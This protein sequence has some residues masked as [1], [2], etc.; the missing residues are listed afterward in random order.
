MT[1]GEIISIPASEGGEFA[2]YLAGPAGPGPALVVIQEIFGINAA[3]R[4]I[5]DRLASAGYLAA[6]PDLFWR[7]EPGVNLTDQTEEDWKRAIE[8]MTGFDTDKGID[9]IQ[10]T[11]TALRDRGATHVGTVGFCLGGKLA[12]LSACRTDSEASVSYYGV[13]IDGLLGEATNIKHPLLMHIAAED[14]FVDKAAQAAIH[15]GLE[16]YSLVTIHDY[17]GV[18]HAFARPNGINFDAEAA[19]LADSRT[20]EF[21][22]KNLAGS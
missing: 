12:Y 1:T 17:P 3:M 4:D 6:C 19:A 8:L 13:G 7:Q 9:D 22:Q 2:A 21:F 18:D 11:I 5:T 14:G 10:T 16:S 20:L 15:A